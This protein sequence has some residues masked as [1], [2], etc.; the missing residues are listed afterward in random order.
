MLGNEDGGGVMVIWL[1]VFVAIIV[2]VGGIGGKYV[3]L[4]CETMFWTWGKDIGIGGVIV[5]VDGTVVAAA[6]V[7]MEG[8]WI[9]I[10]GVEF[11]NEGGNS[12]GFVVVGVVDVVEIGNDDDDEGVVG[13]NVEIFN[14]VC[15]T[16]GDWIEGL[17][18]RACNWSK[19]L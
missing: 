9:V 2:V 19:N 18:S 1:L 12:N 3:G 5:V 11:N 7:V 10:E 16:L 15:G 8:V 13:G 6:V 4:D 14:C 17:F